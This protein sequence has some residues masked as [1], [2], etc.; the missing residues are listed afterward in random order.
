MAKLFGRT[1]ARR[2]LLERVGDVS[3]VGG[4]RR[5]RLAEG[6]EDGVEAIE[7]RTGSGFAFTV[8]PS[9]GL[10]ISFAEYRGAPLCWRSATGDVHPSFYEPEGQ[11]WLRGFYGGLLATCGLTQA[12][13]ASV[14]EDKALGMHGRINY[15][16]ARNVYHDGSWEGDDYVMWAYGRVREASVFGENVRLTR[17]IWARLGEN[18]LFISDLVE[19]LGHDRVPHMIAYH[20]NPGFPVV[21][22]DGRLVSSTVTYRPRDEDA[23]LGRDYYAQFHVP[24][25]SYREKVYYHDMKPDDKGYAWCAAINHNYPDG[26]LGLYVRYLPSQL[27]YLW[28]WKMLGEG[29]YVVGMEPANCLPTGRASERERGALRFLAPGETQEYTIEIGVLAGQGDIAEYEERVRSILHVP[30]PPPAEE[31]V[32]D[33][34]MAAETP[35]IDEVGA[36]KGGAEPVDGGVS[37]EEQISEQTEATATGATEGSIEGVMTDEEAATAGTETPATD[38]VGAMEGPVESA[39]AAVSPNEQI[40]EIMR[41]MEEGSTEEALSDEVTATS[42]TESGQ[43]VPT[44][45]TDSEDTRDREPRNTEVAPSD[46]TRSGASSPAEPTPGEVEA[47]RSPVDAAT[48]EGISPEG[49]QTPPPRPS[50]RHR[51]PEPEA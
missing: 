48:D 32:A 6:P 10:D 22:H 43:V 3:Q 44:E 37:P 4:T 18:R 51:N 47:D 36:T 27:P 21:D 16:P 50:R 19:N 33:A 46:E 31:P 49:E 24:L 15:T 17:R 34:E 13:A 40:A 7:F 23:E 1:W 9:R 8:L 26:G 20:I 28:E 41:E 39:T 38:D 45:T 42:A 12:G 11:G 2:E 30:E 25:H 35:A 29:T 5:I 14:D